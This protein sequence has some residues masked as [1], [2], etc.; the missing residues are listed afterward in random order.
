M[1]LE[2]LKCFVAAAEELHFGRAAQKMG[3]LPASL[4]RHLRLLEESSALASC[5]GQL[6][7][8]P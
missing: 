7:V 4:G 2:Q 6:E 1:E 8:S 3:M 5:P